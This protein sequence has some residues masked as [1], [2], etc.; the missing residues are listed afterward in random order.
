VSEI[1]NVLY[2]V[3]DVDEAIAFYGNGL[4]LALKFR[5]GGRYA[6]LDGGRVTLALAG[7]EEDVT[8]GVAAA[9]FKVKDVPQAVAN[10]EKAGATVVSPP[11]E[12]PHEIRAVLTDP[13]GHPLVV[14]AA[15]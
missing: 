3:A 14:Y 9:S 12:G 4:G 15:K 10:L 8:G 7:P 11:A 2:P 1:G 6:A 5:D 13:W